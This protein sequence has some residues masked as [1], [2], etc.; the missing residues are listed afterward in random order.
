MVESALL[1]AMG[2]ALFLA[3]NFI[4]VAGAFLTLLCPAPL[5]I[6]GLRHSP[7]NAVLG[8]VV[9]SLVSFLFLGLQGGLFFFLGFGILGVG[10]GML[11][12]TRERAVEILFYG[13]IVSLVSKLALVAVMVKLTGVN[14]FSFGDQAQIEAMLDKV[15]DF[16]A[17]HGMGSA[18]MEET[19]RQLLAAF[20]QLPD[21]FPALITMASAVDSY[22]SYSVSRWVAGKVSM[23]ELPPLP[24]FSQWRFPRSVLWAFLL[25]VVVSM[26]AGP[27]G[28]GVLHQASLNLR[29]LIQMLFFIQGLAV[30]WFFMLRRGLSRGVRYLLAAL[31]VL[32]PLLSGLTVMAGLLDLWWDF[33]GRFGGEDR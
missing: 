21:L 25:S 24:A 6:L 16:Y 33:R 11:A 31:L 10:L 1:S 9:A 12:R 32:M 28:Q 3:S 15:F 5:V 7:R 29:I 20:G 19:K 8:M 13:I 18:A 30:A 14:P 27:K 2:A 17:R 23:A 22:L 4:P 26:V